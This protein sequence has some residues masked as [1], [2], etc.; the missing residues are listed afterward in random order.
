MKVHQASYHTTYL[1]YKAR[2]VAKGF[3]QKLG[4]DFGETFANTVTP[5][6]YRLLLA[7]AANNDWEIEQWDVKSAYPNATLHDEVYIQQPT[8]FEDP[9][10]PKLVCHCLKA[11]YGLKQAAREWQLFLRGLLGKHSL[12]PLKSD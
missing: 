3:Q 2:W 9:D 12:E 7:I 8:G 4:V 6:T 11:L 1:Q 5:T 10:N